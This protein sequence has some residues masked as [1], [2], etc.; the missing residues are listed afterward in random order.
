MATNCPTCSLALAS[1]QCG[2]DPQCFLKK[3]LVPHI[4]KQWLMAKSKVSHI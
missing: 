2:C 4:Y 3:T 1:G